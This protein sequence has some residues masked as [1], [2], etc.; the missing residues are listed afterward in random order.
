MK[1]FEKIFIRIITFFL[2]FFIYNFLEYNFLEFLYKFQ[3]L[4]EVHNISFYIVYTT[5]YNLQ[6]TYNLFLY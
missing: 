1:N 2:K 3:N 4:S 5:I 6:F